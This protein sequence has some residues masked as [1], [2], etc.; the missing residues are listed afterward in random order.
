MLIQI[1]LTHLVSNTTPIRVTHLYTR[2]LR[3]TPYT[4]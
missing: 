3:C 2:T 1:I 4:A